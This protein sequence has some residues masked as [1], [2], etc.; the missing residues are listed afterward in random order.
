MGM[1][2]AAITRME[3]RTIYLQ[4]VDA[5]GAGIVARSPKVNGLDA[6]YFGLDTKDTIRMDICQ[7][8]DMNELK[9][10]QIVTVS[11]R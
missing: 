6:E 3:G 2:R 7:G 4:F 11:W 10:G 8:E 1:A 9:E 5:L